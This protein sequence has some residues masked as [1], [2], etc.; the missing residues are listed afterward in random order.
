MYVCMYVSWEASV[1]PSSL[2]LLL[3]MMLCSLFH[4][5]CLLYPVGALRSY[6]VVVCTAMSIGG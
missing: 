5:V 3:A 1:F 2:V 6:V 4:A